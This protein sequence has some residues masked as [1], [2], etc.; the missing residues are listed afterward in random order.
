V[1]F[2]VDVSEFLTARFQFHTATGNIFFVDKCSLW[3]SC[4]SK[5]WCLKVEPC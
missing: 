3:S 2:C 1:K 5:W 4:D